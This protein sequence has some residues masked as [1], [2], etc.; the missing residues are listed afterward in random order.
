MKRWVIWN[1]GEATRTKLGFSLA[2]LLNWVARIQRCFGSM[3]D[4]S[5]KPATKRS[6]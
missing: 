5:A 3:P 1:T 6:C 4:C 2:V